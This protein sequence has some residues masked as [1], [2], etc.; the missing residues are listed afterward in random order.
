MKMAMLF[1]CAVFLLAVPGSRAAVRSASAVR[2]ACGNESRLRRRPKETRSYHG[3]R[4]CE[5]EEEHTVSPLTR[6]PLRSATLSP[7][8]RGGSSPLARAVQRVVRDDAK[9]L[10]VSSPQRG[11]GGR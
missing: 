3:R 2:Y 10:K 11:E 5:Y 6:P 4:L 8:G 7:A 9:A 1:S